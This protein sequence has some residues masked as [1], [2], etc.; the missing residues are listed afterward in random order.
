MR[1]KDELSKP[2]TC[3]G[4]AHPKEMVFVLLSRDVAAPATIRAWC[5]E[6]TRIY[7]GWSVEDALTRAVRPW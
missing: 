5:D 3:M 6:R 7:N 4:N 2:K 1:K